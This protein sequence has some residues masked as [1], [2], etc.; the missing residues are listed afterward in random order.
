MSKYYLDSNILIYLNDP[1][2]I[3]HEAV[4]NLLFDISGNDFVIS[5]LVIDEFLYSVKRYLRLRKYPQN[6]ISAVLYDSLYRVLNLPNLSISNPP[7]RKISQF[8]ILSFMKEYN[9]NPRDSYHL[10][11]ALESGC[12][13]LATFDKDF[14]PIFKASLIKPVQ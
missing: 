13:Y 8:E 4:K 11:I 1:D 14:D 7:T 2:D 6:R 3:K 10:L 9:L 12:D 5:P